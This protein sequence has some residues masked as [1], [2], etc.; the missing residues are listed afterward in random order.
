MIEWFKLGV[1]VVGFGTFEL[2][3]ELLT[4]VVAG[5]VVVVI[6]GILE[7]DGVMVVVILGI[8]VVVDVVVGVGAAVVVILGIMGV[9]DGIPLPGPKFW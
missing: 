2:K 1:I 6:V 4:L 7:V 8:M 3:L 9:V 5:E